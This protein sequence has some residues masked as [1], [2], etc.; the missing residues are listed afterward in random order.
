MK[1]QRHFNKYGESDLLFI[2][3]ICCHPDELLSYEQFFIDSYNPYFNILKKAGSAL[4]FKH[5]EESKR[6]LSLARKGKPLSEEHKRKLSESHKGQ[7]PTKETIAKRIESLKGKV[8]SEEKKRKISEANKGHLISKIGRKKISEANKGRRHTQEW[9]DN[10]SIIMKNRISPMKGKKQ[11]DKWKEAIKKSH[12]EESIRKQA[13]SMRGKNTW[14]KGRVQSP[15][16]LI[17]KSK[18]LKLAWQKRKERA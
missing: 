2:K 3:L 8:C 9:K 15:E 17:K 10:M 14:M 11:S 7:V 16:T 4:G 18:S 12:S 5:T 6:K 1:L 13:E